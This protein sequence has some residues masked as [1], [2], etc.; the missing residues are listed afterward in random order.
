MKKLEEAKKMRDVQGQDG[1]WNYDPYMQGLYNGM[2]FVISV[3]EDRAPVYKKAPDFWGVDV[4][5]PTS[6][7]PT[8][9]GDVPSNNSNS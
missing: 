2:E 6:S 8:E 4:P 7:L 9:A 5:M 3:M 1:N